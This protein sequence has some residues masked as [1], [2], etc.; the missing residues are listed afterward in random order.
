MLI[1]AGY[2]Q[3]S[4]TYLVSD[5]HKVQ[6]ER[7]RM[8]KR[9]SEGRWDDWSNVRVKNKSKTR[10]TSCALCWI[11]NYEIDLLKQS[12]KWSTM[13]KVWS[14]PGQLL[15]G[16]MEKVEPLEDLRHWEN[17]LR[18]MSICYSRKVGKGC[19]WPH[20]HNGLHSNIFA[21]VEIFK[22]S[23]STWATNRISNKR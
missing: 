9:G 16:Y 15:A 3:R 18:T 12:E 4:R 19:T 23:K 11:T 20:S 6:G 1:L 13:W 17:I 10:L 21:P 8:P 7:F 22:Q 14:L 5:F 2:A